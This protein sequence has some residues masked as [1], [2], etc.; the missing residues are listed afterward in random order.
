MRS[1]PGFAL[2]HAPDAM[3]RSEAKSNPELDASCRLGGQR[4]SESRRGE[5]GVHPCHIGVIEEI[6][7]PSIERES[8]RIGFILPV[9]NNRPTKVEVEVRNSGH[10]TQIS[11]NVA[12]DRVGGHQ[13][14]ASAVYAWSWSRSIGRPVIE[15]AIAIIVR[16]GS[17]VV[18]A[19]SRSIKLLC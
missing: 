15:V 14:K 10:R 3:T 19:S 9:K 2:F 4:L 12:I 16:P 1:A 7:A 17:D 11:R 13:A 5:D 8:A 18:W 6:R